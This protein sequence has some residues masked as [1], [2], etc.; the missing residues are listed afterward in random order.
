MPLSEDLLKT[1]PFEYILRRDIGFV[2]P[3]YLQARMQDGF[4]TN[5]CP[6]VLYEE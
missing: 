2:G 3:S 5:S 1:S 4:T 6:V